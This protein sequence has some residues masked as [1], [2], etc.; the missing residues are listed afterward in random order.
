MNKTLFLLFAA[1]L[2]SL[3]TA[4]KA[5]AWGAFHSGYSYHTPG[6]GFYHSG[7]TAAC[8]PY[9]EHTSSHSSS[10]NPQTGFSHSGYGQTSG[11]GGSSAYHS[12][13]SSNG[14]GTFHG[15]FLG[16]AGGFGGFAGAYRRW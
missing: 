11:Y 6:G 2:L 1:A 8:G 13:S 9:G 7:S 5:S 12:S 10:Y 16:A 15:G 4:K 14:Y 3:A